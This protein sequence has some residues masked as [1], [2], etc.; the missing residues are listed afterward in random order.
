M[1]LV[2]DSDADPRGEVVVPAG[3][4][5]Y[6]CLAGAGVDSVRWY[7]ETE[8]TQ[9]CRRC[10]VSVVE[11]EKVCETRAVAMNAIVRVIDREGKDTV[12]SGV[13]WVDEP[14]AAEAQ[15]VV[16][17][18]AGTVEAATASS[19]VASTGYPACPPITVESIALLTATSIGPIDIDAELLAAMG[20]QRT[21]I[22][23]CRHE[24]Q[25]PLPCLQKLNTV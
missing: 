14:L 20:A 7:Q 23:I 8:D 22:H 18:P 2:G 24:T 10:G 12:G 16:G 5:H 6:H 1:E 25:N 9:R 3:L 19:E 13:G 17:G 4:E 15:R 21:L 11:L